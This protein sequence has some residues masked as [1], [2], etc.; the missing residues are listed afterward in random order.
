MPYCRW[1][2][3]ASKISGR[4]AYCIAT[5]GANARHNRREGPTEKMGYGPTSV[6][7]LAL[8]SLG[9]HPQ[10]LPWS[11]R[12]EGSILCASSGP[13]HVRNVIDKNASPKSSGLRSGIVTSWTPSFSPAAIT[14]Q[15]KRVRTR[16]LDS[17]QHR[18]AAPAASFPS[19]FPSPWQTVRWRAS[20]V[21]WYCAQSLVRCTLNSWRA[22]LLAGARSY[23][24]SH[25]LEV[26][27]IDAAPIRAVQ[28]EEGGLGSFPICSVSRANI[29]VALCPQ[30]H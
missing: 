4:S 9:P 17:I 15:S 13:E 16:Q 2:R 14:A 28:G 1:R 10:F 25:T 23:C 27:Q 11:R 6:S 3:D 8:A 24:P 29:G 21:P 12:S 7:E 22:F 19:I 30:L 5:L 26:R 20:I 18:C